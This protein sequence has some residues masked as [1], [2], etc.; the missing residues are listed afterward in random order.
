MNSDIV[1]MVVLLIMSLN[2]FR[3]FGILSFLIMLST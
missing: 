2:L 1:D 3:M